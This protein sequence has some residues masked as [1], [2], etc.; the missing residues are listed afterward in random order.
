MEGFLYLISPFLGSGFPLTKALHADY[1]GEGLHLGTDDFP[2][3]AI[4][5][6]LGGLLY[7]TLKGVEQ[8]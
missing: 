8:W 7:I 3:F 6:L 5:P 1:I 2:G 4:R